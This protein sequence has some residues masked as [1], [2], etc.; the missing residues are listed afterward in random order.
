MGLALGRPCDEDMKIN[1]DVLSPKS[2]RARRRRRTPSLFYPSGRNLIFH[3]S[4]LGS[5]RLQLSSPIFID[6]QTFAILPPSDPPRTILI[7]SISIIGLL[8]SSLLSDRFSALLAHS[9]ESKY[10]YRDSLYLLLSSSPSV[11][12]IPVA[13]A[14]GLVAW[15]R[16]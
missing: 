11:S 7:S 6:F 13:A 3:S 4:L 12:L 14:I 1:L 2:I 10:A 9:I 5:V 16:K 8:L 15:H